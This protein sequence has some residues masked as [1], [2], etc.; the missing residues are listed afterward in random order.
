ML[1]NTMTS[2][3]KRKSIGK[4][5]KHQDETLESQ[6]KANEVTQPISLWQA[7]RD[8]SITDEDSNTMEKQKHVF[9]LFFVARVN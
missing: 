1:E 8:D 9:F 2:R 7:L 6:T 4:K 5:L 3:A